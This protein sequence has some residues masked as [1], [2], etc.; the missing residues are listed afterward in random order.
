MKSFLITPEPGH[1][2]EVPLAPASSNDG[3]SNETQGMLRMAFIQTFLILRQFQPGW[4]QH[5]NGF[6][7][8]CSEGDLDFVR[9]AGHF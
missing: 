5:Q 4:F 2:L 1:G 3:Q 7:L 6:D 8:I 9:Q